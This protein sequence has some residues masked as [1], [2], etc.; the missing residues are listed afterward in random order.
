M[1]EACEEAVLAY[2]A[3]S[4][5]TVIEDTFPWSEANKLEH[6]K[7][8]GALK[9]LEADAFVATEPLSASFY[10]LTKEGESILANGAQEML[11]LKAVEAAGKMSMPDL[12][13]AVGKDVAKIGMGNCMKN[14]WMKKDGGDLVPLK[15]SDEVQDDIQNSLKAL[16]EVNFNPDAVDA[17]VCI[18][19][20]AV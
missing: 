6:L 2:L 5:D 3:K 20:D 12:Q 1:T 14:K 19:C 17:K 9:S 7:V 11:V 18:F 13:K 15:K 10:S 8:V 4:D 16:A